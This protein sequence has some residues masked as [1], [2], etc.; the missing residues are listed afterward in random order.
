MKKFSYLLRFSILYSLISLSAEAQNGCGFV[1][2]EEFMNRLDELKAT[3][4]YKTTGVSDTLPIAL[5]LVANDQGVGRH[6]M[7]L[8]MRNICDLNDIYEDVGLYF[9]VQW[10]IDY[11]NNSNY[12]VHSFQD[13]SIMMYQ[14]NRSSVLN[15]YVVSDPSG[16]CGYYSPSRDAIALAKS[17]AGI[18][19]MTFA[20]EMGHLLNLPHTFSGWEHGQTPSNPELVTRGAGSNCNYRGDHFC[21]T[22][23]DYLSNRWSCPY[24]GTKLDA[25]GDA[26]HPDSSLIM[27][28]SSDNCQSRFSSQQ[29]GVMISNKNSRWNSLIHNYPARVDQFDTAFIQNIT[30]TLYNNRLIEWNAVPGATAYYIQLSP[31]TSTSYVLS[32]TL[33]YN[34]TQLTLPEGKLFINR[35][36]HIRIKPVNGSSL[37][38]DFGGDHVF[39]YLDKTG[40]NNWPVGV[41]NAENSDVQYHL[42]YDHKV[43]TLHY[44]SKLHDHVSITLTDVMGR[45]LAIDEQSISPGAS[46]LA[47]PPLEQHRGQ[48]LLIH[49]SLKDGSTKTLKLLSE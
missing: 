9:W 11:I 24:N 41:E 10:P 8:A 40:P 27:N 26:Y 37:C 38:G 31:S 22:E 14:N 46:T 28:Y 32:D 16:N 13:G 36:H 17:C 15:V 18:G 23:A 35:V 30:D 2:T 25:N 19:E 49:L 44:K 48:L 33:V 4:S 12:Y 34:T 39:T 21:D 3:T 7:E 43:P 47:L 42:S 1:P 45:T 29:K 6:S 20:H 5:H